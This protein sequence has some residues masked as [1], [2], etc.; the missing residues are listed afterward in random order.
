MNK[1]TFALMVVALLIAFICGRYSLPAKVTVDTQ[2]DTTKDLVI[3][4][5]RSQLATKLSD[6]VSTTTTVKWPDGKI[7]T[8][9]KNETKNKQ[10]IESVIQ[11]NESEK[12]TSH[13]EKHTVT[14]NTRGIVVGPMVNFTTHDFA[15]PLV[16]G[17][18]D[19]PLFLGAHVLGNVL[20]GPSVGISAGGALGWE[21]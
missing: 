7:V 8:R 4:S 2:K 21:F 19:A 18:F 3:Q 12:Q 15:H 6:V 11:I 20:V 1:K 5:L 14:E 9:V 13:T 16:G 10:S 17:I